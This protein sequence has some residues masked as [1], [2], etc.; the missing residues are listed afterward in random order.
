MLTWIPELPAEGWRKVLMN[1][2]LTALVVAA[3]AVFG[4]LVANTLAG[5]PTIAVDYI[6]SIVLAVILT[7]PLYGTLAIKLQQMRLLTIRLHE[8]A[9]TDF[10]TGALNRGAFVTEVEKLMDSGAVRSTTR[11][12]ALLV[13]DVDRFKSINDRF[14]HQAGDLALVRIADALRDTLKEKGLLGR[15]GGEEFGVFM[16]SIAPDQAILAA[17]ACRVA[18]EQCPFSPLGEE[19]SLSV[20]IGVAIARKRDDFTSLFKQAD[21]CLYLAKNRGRNRVEVETSALAA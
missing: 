18:V 4:T 16:P 5:R 11:T 9:T 14:G 2:G 3:L 10:L 17:E 21:A 1:T 15:L 6:A 12:S 7:V 20:S 8:L 13:I 19:Q